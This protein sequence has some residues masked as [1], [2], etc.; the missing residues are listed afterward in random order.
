MS[1]PNSL[2]AVRCVDRHASLIMAVISALSQIKNA[3]SYREYR[4][5][6]RE[7]KAVGDDTRNFRSR[8][9]PIYVF[10]YVGT[11]KALSAKDPI[12]I[13]YWVWMA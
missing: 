6:I 9:S 5:D 2:S 12:L 3:V 4:R 13:G 8:R 11:R 10:S 1:G 7:A